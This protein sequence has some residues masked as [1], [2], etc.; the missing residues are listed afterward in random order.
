MTNHYRVVIQLN[1]A[2]KRVQ[3]ATLGQIE[4]ILKS[5]EE[6]Y[7]ELVT[8]GDGVELLYKNS[9]YINVIEDLHKKGVAL[10]VCN[11]TLTSKNLSQEDFLTGI[12]VLDSAVVHLIKRQN[13]GWAYLKAG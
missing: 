8:H 6:I 2:E 7:I 12:T 4:N 5:D 1:T 11:N 10:V 13:E 3:K 9:E